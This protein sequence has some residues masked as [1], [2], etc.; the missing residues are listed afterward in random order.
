MAFEP[1]LDTLL[2]NTT[3]TQGYDGSTLGQIL[4]QLKIIALILR[5]G[6]DSNLR[7]EDITLLEQ[8]KPPGF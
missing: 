7:D 1:P 6:F 3:L 2:D 8:N 4:V 5:E